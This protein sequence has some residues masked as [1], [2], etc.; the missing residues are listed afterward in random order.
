MPSRSDPRGERG[1]GNTMR[2]S[3]IQRQ[4]FNFLVLPFE[5]HLGYT[6][7][8][9]S[10]FANHF[11]FSPELID[12]A[13]TI[14]AIWNDPGVAI[15]YLAH[16]EASC[17]EELA[18]TW[19]PIPT[20]PPERCPDCWGMNTSEHSIKGVKVNFLCKDCG[21]IFRARFRAD[22]KTKLKCKQLY[23]SGM[24]ARQV[25]EKT[26]VDQSLI[27][28]WMKES[29]ITKEERCRLQR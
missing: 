26:G 23:L 15:R 7:K 28:Y 10:I 9:L 6:E 1:K 20:L 11:S 21:N 16:W 2:M 27:A 19:F 24:T 4:N 14:G 17:C 22:V 5:A 18:E 3:D 13:K 29:G 8:S 12:L 25:S